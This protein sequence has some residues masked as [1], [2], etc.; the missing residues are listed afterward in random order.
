MTRSYTRSAIGSIF[1]V[2]DSAVGQRFGEAQPANPV[3]NRD[4]WHFS[5]LTANGVWFSC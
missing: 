3:T 1:V 5:S 4:F 2:I